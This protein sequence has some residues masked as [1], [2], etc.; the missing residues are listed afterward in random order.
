[1]KPTYN[2]DF[3]LQ[4]VC[5]Y[6][7]I[8]ENQIIS[9]SRR[10][11]IVK[12]RHIFFYLCVEYSEYSMVKIGLFLNRNHAT[13]IHAVKRIKREKFMYDDI[14][15]P[16]QMIE[17]ILMCDIDIQDLNLL[18]IAKYNTLQQNISTLN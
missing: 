11:D 6:F 8:T 7:A 12:I 1:M 4:C 10:A 13:V 3:I 15:I 16:L 2:L 17:K 18:E 5:S 9:P 14:T